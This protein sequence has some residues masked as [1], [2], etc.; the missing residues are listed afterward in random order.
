[1]HPNELGADPLDSSA[2]AHILG[3]DL[4]EETKLSRRSMSAIATAFLRFAK[5]IPTKPP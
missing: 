5:L 3:A 4:A 1:M 2:Y